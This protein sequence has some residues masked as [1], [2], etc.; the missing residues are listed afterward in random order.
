MIENGSLTGS[1]NAV[2]A[3]AC[4]VKCVAAGRRANI[5][6][7]PKWA[8]DGGNANVAVVTSSQIGTNCNFTPTSSNRGNK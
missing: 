2:D 6:C 8:A 7:F 5:V 1:A 3:T 4:S